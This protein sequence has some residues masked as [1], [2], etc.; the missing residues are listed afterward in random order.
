MTIE[1]IAELPFSND[2]ETFGPFDIH[3]LYRIRRDAAREAIIQHAQQ[4]QFEQRQK[5]KL[6]FWYHAP[7]AF[8]EFLFILLASSSSFPTALTILMGMRIGAIVMALCPPP[9]LP[10]KWFV[11][12]L[13]LVAIAQIAVGC[14]TSFDSQ[15]SWVLVNEIVFFFFGVCI[16]AKCWDAC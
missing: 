12:C 16:C 14:T 6:M 9:K 15:Q 2:Q 3:R 5:R 7:A 4:I 13:F 11:L 10:T 1:V 8:C